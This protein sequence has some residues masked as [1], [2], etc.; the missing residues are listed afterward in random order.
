MTLR[1]YL[2]SRGTIAKWFA[3]Q[4]GISY[5][6]INK[7]MAGEKATK[8]VAILIEKLTNGEVKADELIK[9]SKNEN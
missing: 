2:K 3:E 7:I 4:V 8:P 1:E 9:G 6:V 5:R